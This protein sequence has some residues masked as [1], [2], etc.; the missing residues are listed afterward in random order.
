[1]AGGAAVTELGS[2]TD[3]ATRDYRGVQRDVSEAI[4]F[5]RRG[6]EVFEHDA[7]GYEACDEGA[8]RSATGHCF[9]ELT[10]DAGDGAVEAGVPEGG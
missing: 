2:K 5:E 3:E 1:M 8:R 4:Y 9:A 10:G 7:G 6:D